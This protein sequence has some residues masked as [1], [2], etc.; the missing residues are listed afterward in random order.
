MRTFRL[1]RKL[2]LGST[3]GVIVAWLIIAT[4]LIALEPDVG[5]GSPQRLQHD[6]TNALNSRDRE[7][8]GSLIDYPTGRASEFAE[9]YLAKLDSVGANSIT[10]ALTPDEQA[11]SRVTIAGMY[12]DGSEF[13]YNV[14]ATQGRDG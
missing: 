6:L 1:T 8:L 13:S 3:V 7:A 11:P 9:S 10:V 4:A 5:V 12:A 14:A 2:A